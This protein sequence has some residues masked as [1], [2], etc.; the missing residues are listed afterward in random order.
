MAKT[1]EEVKSANKACVKRWRKTERGRKK[2]AEQQSRWR[3]TPHG[4]EYT[5]SYSERVKNV[6][7]E[8]RN[9]PEGKKKA[10]NQY[11]KKTYGIDADI[12]HNILY[13]QNNKCAICGSGDWES[14]SRAMDLDHDHET[15]KVRGILCH[16]CNIAIGLLSDNPNTIYAAAVYLR[17]GSRFTISNKR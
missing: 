12:Y 9:T 11:L 14:K 3:K 6:V 1:P 8:K 10:F 4:I 16:S 17:D 7:K 5:K 13:L 15:G 2:M